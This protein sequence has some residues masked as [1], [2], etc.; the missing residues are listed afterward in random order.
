MKVR[1]VYQFLSN[2]FEL[3]FGKF[4]TS[5]GPF[6]RGNLSISNYSPALDQVLVKLKD[7]KELLFHI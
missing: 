4:K 7:E 2:S 6:F 3:V 1:L 5:F